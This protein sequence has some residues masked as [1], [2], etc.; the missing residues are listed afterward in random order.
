MRNQISVGSSINA[1]IGQH[2]PCYSS[3]FQKELTALTRNCGAKLRRPGGLVLRDVRKLSTDNS[4]T[5][6]LNFV[7]PRSLDTANVH[8]RSLC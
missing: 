5:R 8:T 4:K 6:S 7:Y 2:N 1:Q 3:V